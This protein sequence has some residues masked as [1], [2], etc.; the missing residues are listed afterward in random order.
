MATKTK[1]N[2]DSMTAHE[3]VRLA[4]LEY[5][6]DMKSNKKEVIIT[7]ETSHTDIKVILDT[8]TLLYD[9]RQWQDDNRSGVQK[10]I[11]RGYEIV[12]DKIQVKHD[13]YEFER[14]GSN[15]GYYL[16]TYRQYHE[17]TEN[18]YTFNRLEYEY[19]FREHDVQGI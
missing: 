11:V 13:T 10:A 2:Y 6:K 8:M 18:P 1:V 16:L 19:I 15:K 7:D 12:T 3:Q 17:P 5:F 4:V 9:V 14:I